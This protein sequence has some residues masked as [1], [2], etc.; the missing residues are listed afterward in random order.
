M[1]Q[2]GIADKAFIREQIVAEPAACLFV[3]FTSD[4][5]EQAV[6]FSGHLALQHR[7]PQFSRVAVI[8]VGIFPDVQLAF[9]IFAGRQG[10]QLVNVELVFG[11]R[12]KQRRCHT[13]QP[14]EFLNVFSAVTQYT[15]DLCRRFPFAAHFTKHRNLVGRVHLFMLKVLRCGDD[16]CHLF[17]DGLHRHR[18]ICGDHPAI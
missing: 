10:L 3:S 4:K 8:A 11:Q 15:R 5:A 7:F 6:A 2:H 9:L 13:C 14:Q 18:V 1:K 17:A 16:F 12:R